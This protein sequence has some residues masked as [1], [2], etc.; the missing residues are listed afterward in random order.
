MQYGVVGRATFFTTDAF[1]QARGNDSRKDQMR[2]HTGL[3]EGPKDAP[4]AGV[5][6]DISRAKA[7]RSRPKIAHCFLYVWHDGASQSV[8][9][10]IATWPFQLN[11][12]SRPNLSPALIAFYYRSAASR[13][14]VTIGM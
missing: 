2:A 7:S 9:S 13:L 10:R 14:S 6:C 3:D 12:C 8:R 5:K 1:A 11:T 4:L